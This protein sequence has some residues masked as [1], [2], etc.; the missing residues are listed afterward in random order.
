LDASGQSFSILWPATNPAC[1]PFQALTNFLLGNPFSSSQ[2]GTLPRLET[3]GNMSHLAR[4]VWEEFVHLNKTLLEKLWV[5]R[6]IFT[7]ATDM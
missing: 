7:P 5:F 1:K 4:F 6:K 2:L 3:P